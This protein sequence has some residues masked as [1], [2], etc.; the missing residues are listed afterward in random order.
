MKKSAAAVVPGLVGVWLFS[1]LG[2]PVV[3]AADGPFPP[4]LIAFSQAKEQ[5][6]RQLAADL[7]IA[8]PPEIRDFFR[9]PGGAITRR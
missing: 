2:G 6:V 8:E 9:R 1:T 4:Q 3:R 5:Q 7:K